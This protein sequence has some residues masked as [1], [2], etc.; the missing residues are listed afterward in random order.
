MSR[1]IRVLVFLVIVALFVTMTSF[2]QLTS[3]REG[4]HQVLSDLISHKQTYC[5]SYPQTLQ[6]DLLPQDEAKVAQE[7]LQVVCDIKLDDLIKPETDLSPYSDAFNQYQKKMNLLWDKVTSQYK[8][9][10]E[11]ATVKKLATAYKSQYEFSGQ[12]YLLKSEIEIY[13]RTLLRGLN[14]TVNYL[15]TD[16]KL[17]NSLE[18]TVEP[19]ASELRL[20]KSVD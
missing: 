18:L 6:L 10:D 20:K 17:Y 12:N 7:A 4:M 9:S 2:F 14:S 16:L 11:E 13:N 3:Q 19:A 1:T 15:F 8:Q 5:E